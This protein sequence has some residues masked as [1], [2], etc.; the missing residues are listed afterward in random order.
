MHFMIYSS[1]LWFVFKYI[2][3]SLDNIYY[4]QTDIP[5]NVLQILLENHTYYRIYD[6]IIL[7][8]DA[9]YEF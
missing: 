8:F 1:Y 4:L 5:N 3:I 2:H 7:E 6:L 9:I